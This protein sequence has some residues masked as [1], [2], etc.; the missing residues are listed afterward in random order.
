MP[1]VTIGLNGRNYDIACGEGEEARVQEL[2]GELRRRMEG[3]AKNAGPVAENLLFT[4]TGLLLADELDQ[5]NRQIA[6]LKGQQ[7]DLVQRREI[8]LADTIE[9]LAVKIEAIAAR[10]EAA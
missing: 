2:A 3:L 6:Q 7:E 5:K 4:L 9:R 8:A 1:T 10:L